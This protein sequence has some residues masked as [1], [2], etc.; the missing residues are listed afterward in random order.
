MKG[1][2]YMPEK[3]KQN[4]GDTEQSN[5]RQINPE[6]YNF[7]Q[8]QAVQK[9]RTEHATEREELQNAIRA[10]RDEL[11]ELKLSK[12]S[13][14]QKSKAEGVAEA[15]QLME[16]VRSLRDELESQDADAVA[17]AQQSRAEHIA[18]SEQL[19]KTI[20][21]LRIQLE[22]TSNAWIQLRSR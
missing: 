5:T 7:E 12:D 20:E 16:T 15:Q 21:Q 4:G 1:I 9:L 18:Q 8:D 10:L 19:Q 2:K 17:Q 14:I 13:D 11:E 22:K 3:N 6:G